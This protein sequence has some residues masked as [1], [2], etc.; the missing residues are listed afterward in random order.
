MDPPVLVEGN[1]T[2]T[3]ELFVSIGSPFCFPD[4]HVLSIKRGKGGDRI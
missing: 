2:L 4:E 1:V 3:K